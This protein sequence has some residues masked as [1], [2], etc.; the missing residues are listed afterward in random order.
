M[1][2][3]GAYILGLFVLFT[4]T[5]CW[6]S[7]QEYCDMGNKLLSENNAADAMERFEAALRADSAYTPAWEGKGK[8]LE[9]M[10]KWMDARNFYNDFIE[11]D[12][13]NAHPYL[14]LGLV[15]QRLRDKESECEVYVR[16]YTLGVKNYDVLAMVPMCVRD[17]YDEKMRLLEEAIAMDP[18]RYE[19]KA[20]RLELM[21]KYNSV[22]IVYPEALKLLKEHSKSPKVYYLMSK[23]HRGIPY[24]GA[25][26]VCY[27]L[28]KCINM[29]YYEA[30]DD[31][32]LYGCRQF[33]KK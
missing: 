2:R 21:M 27:Y 16:A 9:A 12:K 33:E 14:R 5:G 23:V 10:N 22:D 30:S 3:I 1:K 4:I 11:R 13:M 6:P 8:C 26:S 18:S 17:T 25:D 20:A 15:Y 24:S 31:Y 32:Y 19:A 29:K 7:A 28:Q